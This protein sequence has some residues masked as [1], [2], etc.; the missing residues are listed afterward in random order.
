MSDL[1]LRLYEP[2]GQRELALA[3]PRV[4]L[5][6][7]GRWE[8]RPTAGPEV[9]LELCAGPEG[10][11]LERA[12]PGVTIN[13]QPFSGPRLLALGDR[14]AFGA[15]GLEVLSA[16]HSTASGSRGSSGSALEPSLQSPGSAGAGVRARP[17]APGETL[18]RYR[19][20]E[21]LGSGAFGAV[22]RATDTQL[23]REVAL[24]LL[25]RPSERARQRFLREAKAS[26]RLEHPHLITTHDA[27]ELEGGWLFLAMQLVRGRSLLEAARDPATAR[28]DLLRWVAQAARGVAHAN[29]E[30]V[31]H[32]DLKPANVMI[33]GEGK[34]LVV[35]FGMAAFEEEDRA[36][37]TQTGATL[38]TPAYM[39]PEVLFGGSKE[40]SA[41]SEVYALGATLF[42]VV[43]GALP[44]EDLHSPPLSLSEVLPDAD[45]RLVA[46]CARAMA[47]DGHERYPDADAL[48]D[49]IE[50]L[51]APPGAARAVRGPRVAV[52]ALAALGLVGLA[53]AAARG[54]RTEE[55]SAAAAPSAS[56]SAAP[57]HGGAPSAGALPAPSAA[58]SASPGASPSAALAGPAR[59]RALLDEV[60]RGRRAL[61]ATAALLALLDEAATA[62]GED[63]PLRA[64]VGAARL[65][66]LVARRQLSG[67]RTALAPARAATPSAGDPRGGD[68]A[69]PGGAGAPLAL[70]LLRARGWLLLDR[71]RGLAIL[72]ELAGG[73]VGAPASLGAPRGDPAQRLAAARWS[74]ELGA[75]ADA[76]A[77]LDGLQATG[78][79]QRLALPLSRTRARCA[80]ALGDAAVARAALERLAPLPDDV[81]AAL[82]RALLGAPAGPESEALAA[83]LERAER[84]DPDAVALLAGRALAAKVPAR[85]RSWL[86]LVR[87]DLPFALRLL[88]ARAAEPDAAAAAVRELAAADPLLF[89]R[90][91]SGLSE[92]AALWAAAGASQA[93]GLLAL[94]GRALPAEL[95]AAARRAPEP[96]RAPLRAALE[97]AVRG[98]PWEGIAPAL[99]RAERAAEADPEVAAWAARLAL[100]RDRFVEALAALERARARGADAALLER[101]DAELW[102]RRGD[103]A[104][105]TRRY[106][107]ASRLGGAEGAAAAA[108]LAWLRADARAGA[109]RAQ[110]SLASAPGRAPGWVALAVCQLNLGQP[111]AALE[112]AERAVALQGGLDA[113]ALMFRALAWARA[114]P[115]GAHAR[116]GPLE[117]V[118]ALTRGASARLLGA[119]AAL[120]LPDAAGW[121]RRVLEE[122]RAYE[123]RRKE[124]YLYLGLLDL[125]AGAPRERVLASWRRVLALDPGYSLPEAARRAYEER[126]GPLELGR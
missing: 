51:L 25:T 117:Q 67:L 69:D 32:R 111:A 72:E 96:A 64:R 100:G 115:G 113:R 70:R 71:E 104:S 59:V 40:A 22:F 77:W 57:S 26:A 6:W 53:L 63:A 65:E 48:A 30:G 23:G 14:I 13:G 91:T 109:A 102:L 89:A 18:G 37:L 112:S 44:R 123:P 9:V 103:V 46:V 61:R 110:E 17:P 7:S 50:E 74:L 11:R 31:L 5:G 76:W 93:A 98:E 56:A 73:L 47:H 2:T 39:A 83:A 45:P 95:A 3:Q 1:R 66:L 8:P 62:A 87:G 108:E 120:S 19:L 21:A 36:R 118:L 28:A 34:A 105:A 124:I 90:E 116:L 81:D 10:H 43:S 80:T 107:Q 82:T 49:A 125:R 78:Q 119:Q 41:A 84:A 35:D 75:A 88:R 20:E 126:H 106:E 94:E 92:R 55:A 122:A 29:Q 27:G 15:G 60:A 52:A 54:G 38:G 101:L 4:L 68:L 121:T 42:H 85:A 86:A 79:A 97:A 33:A 58:S 12:R 24:K 99:A 16:P 114:R